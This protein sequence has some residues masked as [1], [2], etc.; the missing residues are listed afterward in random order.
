VTNEEKV[1]YYFNDWKVPPISYVI[2]KQTDI[3]KNHDEIVEQL[4]A[5]RRN[6]A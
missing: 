2:K 3:D 6:L 5:I 1:I 4:I